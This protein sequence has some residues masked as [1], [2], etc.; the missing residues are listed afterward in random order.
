MTDEELIARLRQDDTDFWH[1]E[2]A[3]RIEALTE[4]LTAARADSKEADAHAVELESDRRKTY[5]ALLLMSRLHSEVEAKLAK[6]VEA[7]QDIFEKPRSADWTYAEL[8]SEM[9]KEAREALAEISSEAA[10]NKGET[11]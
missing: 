6:A 5:E 9:K 11:E 2:A 8:I 3:D 1:C 4:Q 10:L 7:L